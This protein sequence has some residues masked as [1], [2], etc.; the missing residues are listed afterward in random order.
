MK[1]IIYIAGPVSTG[2]A[3]SVSENAQRMIRW[4]KWFVRNDTSRVYIAP[5]VA[6]VLAFSGDILEPE[7]YQRVLDDDC[8]VV[9]HMNG[10]VGVGTGPGGGWTKGMSQERATARALGRPVLDM[11]KFSEPKDINNY[12]HFFS[13]EDEWKLATDPMIYR[14]PY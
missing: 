4:V 10:L 3:G 7:F 14:E 1:P 9:S 8:D 11:T 13:V 2:G 6:E 5:W 12:P